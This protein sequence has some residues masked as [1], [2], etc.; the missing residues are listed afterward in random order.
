MCYNLF[1]LFF[2][3]HSLI[4]EGK[5]T[6]SKLSQRV[7]AKRVAAMEVQ[8]T[9]RPINAYFNPMI[10]RD[11]AIAADIQS[12]RDPRPDWS[13]LVAETASADSTT[14]RKIPTE[15]DDRED[16]SGNSSERAEDDLDGADDWH[17]RE[18]RAPTDDGGS[19]VTF[20]AAIVTV[21]S[22]LT[23][24]NSFG[25]PVVLVAAETVSADTI[26]VDFRLK[27]EEDEQSKEVEDGTKEI[28]EGMQGMQIQLKPHGPHGGK[29]KCGVASD[30]RGQEPSESTDVEDQPYKFS[31][32]DNITN[33]SYDFYSALAGAATPR[34]Q[35]HGQSL[36]HDPPQTVEPT[37]QSLPPLSTGYPID[38]NYIFLGNQPDFCQTLQNYPC[39]HNV[40]P[41]NTFSNTNNLYPNTERTNENYRATFADLP[42]TNVALPSY[43]SM[44]GYYLPQRIES[45]SMPTTVAPASYPDAY[46]VYSRIPTNSSDLIRQ[47]PRQDNDFSSLRTN[48]TTIQ[49]PIL[50]QDAQSAAPVT[51]TSELELIYEWVNEQPETR[52][53]EPVE[54]G[55]IEHYLPPYI[56]SI[57]TS[58]PSFNSEAYTPYLQISTDS[59]DPYGIWPNHIPV[60]VSPPTGQIPAAPSPSGSLPHS[61]S[62]SLM[63]TSPRST[64][65]GSDPAADVD[66]ESRNSP[67]SDNMVSDHGSVA[68]SPSSV[69]E[70]GNTIL[71]G[72]ELITVLNI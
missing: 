39:R 59:S 18:T 23:S 12:Y 49:S 47:Y 67:G 33:G 27:N 24:M 29:P 50:I 13:L 28:E 6:D 63:E 11:Q 26:G 46:T 16:S 14:P 45:L 48:P 43:R 17:V 65:P 30:G 60:N 4:R 72:G 66:A 54:P 20:A 10:T 40:R 62:S 64:A 36:W 51:A 22:P 69:S 37:C 70:D 5:G 42:S 8:T 57:P 56:G 68:N 9:L 32:P 41:E 21:K 52:S 3:K 1:L 25:E 38:N 31:R 35:F 61:R 7:T 53:P 55:I 58:A 44:P 34:M 19:E 71:I 15:S 2:L